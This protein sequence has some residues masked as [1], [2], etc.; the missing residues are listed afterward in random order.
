MRA[1]VL[2]PRQSG[3]GHGGARTGLPTRDPAVSV[4][5][6]HPPVSTLVDRL[7]ELTPGHA[8]PSRCPITVKSDS[9]PAQSRIP[10]MGTWCSSISVWPDHFGILAERTEWGFSTRSLFPLPRSRQSGPHYGRRPP[11]YW[12]LSS[13]T[14]HRHFPVN[15]FPF[16]SWRIQADRNPTK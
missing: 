10:L 5:D 14:F 6:G 12:A 11:A 8:S 4:A 9:L 13:F 15:R 2:F 1:Y 16:A 7:E 3:T